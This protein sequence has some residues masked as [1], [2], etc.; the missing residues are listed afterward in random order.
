MPK[1]LGLFSNRGLTTFLASCF[2]TTAGAGATFF[3]LAFFPFG[4]V[5]TN[6][7][8]RRGLCRFLCRGAGAGAWPPEDECGRRATPP[9]ARASP[10]PVSAPRRPGGRARLVHQRSWWSGQSSPSLREQIFFHIICTSPA[11]PRTRG[12]APSPRRGSGPPLRGPAGSKQQKRAKTPRGPRR[13]ERTPKKWRSPPPPG[14]RR[15]SAPSVPEPRTAALLSSD[16]HPP[17][18]GEV[19]EC[20]PAPRPLSEVLRGAPR[21]GQW[22]H[23]GEVALRGG[24]RRIELR[25]QSRHHERKANSPS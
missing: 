6:T 25:R 14:H 7:S 13:P 15:A 22:R 17:L 8:F 2:F 5:R 23:P 12:A 19:G 21:S 20:Y 16:P 10:T 4:W 11:G 1:F 24:W 18:P 3:P 9:P